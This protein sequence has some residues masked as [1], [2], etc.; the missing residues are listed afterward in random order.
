MNRFNP[1][2]LRSAAAL[3]AATVLLGG[4]AT[5]SKDIATAYV[6]PLQFQ[7]YDCSQ[8][9]A[10]SVRVH[11]RV[12]QLGGR[13]DQAAQND[14]AI[15][16]VGAILFWPA[17]FALGGTK[18]QEAEYARLKGEHEAIA[19]TAIVKKC[20]GTAGVQQVNAPAG[21]ASA[22]QAIPAALPIATPAPAAPASAVL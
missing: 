6:S 10:E 4:C 18:E 2:A 15:V 22:P 8:L 17:L 1:A 21:T 11:Q 20:E 7:G 13:L 14:K 3:I 19:Q 12:T 5:A 9:T 16:G